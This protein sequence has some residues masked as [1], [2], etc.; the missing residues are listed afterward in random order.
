MFLEETA[1]KITRDTGSR[2]HLGLFGKH[3]AWDD[4]MED[5]G[6]ATDSLIEFKRRLYFGG[7]S[8]CI[9]SGAWTDLAAD[10]RIDA[11][12]H[13]LIWSGP[14]GIVFAVL[15]HSSDGR[16]RREYPMVA[17]AHFP[18][19]HLPARVGPVFDALQGVA[20][21]CRRGA[22]IDAIRMAQAA[23]V[24]SLIAA[25]RSLVP[26]STATWDIEDR[27]SF[28]SHPGLGEDFR[29]FHR[30]FYSMRL[31][32]DSPDPRI[33]ARLADAGSGTEALLV[34]QV[35]LRAQMAAGALLL[36]FRHR[37]SQWLDAIEGDPRPGDWLRLRALPAEVP[38]TTDIP[39]EIDQ[40]LRD[41][42]D[43]V[44]GS[45]I[46]D[47]QRIPRIDSCGSE[48]PGQGF[49]GSLLSRFFRQSGGS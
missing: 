43:M 47:P 25:A 8:G 36:T 14:A 2:L 21:A 37:P 19:P 31:A 26:L 23:G 24:E 49:V 28:V 38:L 4:H 10:A 1:E 33:R 27:R 17:A 34:W 42:A 48:G 22:N 9:D 35:L 15:W 20:D 7:I 40:D 6:M 3:P 12:D 18:T 11:F 30:L 44:I 13:E 41:C 46:E 45:F 29:G 32:A 5:I 16:G 39:Y